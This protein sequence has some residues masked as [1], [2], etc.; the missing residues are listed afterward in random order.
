MRA[1]FIGVLIVLLIAMILIVLWPAIMATIGAVLGF[2]SLKKLLEA[3]S[4]S[5]KVIYGVLIGVG[6]LIILAN[7]KGILVVAIIGAIIYFLTRNRNKPRKN[8]DVFDYPYNK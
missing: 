4:V 2:W 5:E 6:A 3:R 1:I 8:D 7:L